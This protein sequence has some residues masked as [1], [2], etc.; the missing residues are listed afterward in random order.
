MLYSLMYSYFGVIP[1]CL[2][3]IFRRFG[4]LCSIFISGVS[5]FFLAPPMNMEHSVPKRR[6][7]KFRRRG[8]T[9][10]NTTF[11]T[12]RKF[13]IKDIFCYFMSRRPCVGVTVRVLLGGAGGGFMPTSIHLKWSS[14]QSWRCNYFVISLHKFRWLTSSVDN[15]IFHEPTN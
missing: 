3:F 6:H 5:V 2:N 15:A 1:C 9:Q 8:I 11:R 7:I 10:S 12:R 14:L 13:E 4:T